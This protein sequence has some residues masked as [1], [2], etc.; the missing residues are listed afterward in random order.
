MLIRVLGGGS[1]AEVPIRVTMATEVRKKVRDGGRMRACKLARVFLQADPIL[2]GSIVRW[3]FVNFSSRAL[4]YR[5][6]D[7]SS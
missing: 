4:S 2:A 7:A 1:A 6:Q 5:R 3:R